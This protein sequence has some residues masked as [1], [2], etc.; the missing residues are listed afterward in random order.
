MIVL[1]LYVQYV[2][3]HVDLV[4]HLAQVTSPEC[5]AMGSLIEAI[6]NF[7]L[8]MYPGQEIH[9]YYGFSIVDSF[10]MLY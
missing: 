8:C 10:C 6:W 5:F 9:H 3:L 4:S 2:G 1:F 7:L